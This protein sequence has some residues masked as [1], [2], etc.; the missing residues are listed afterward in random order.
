MEQ[1]S[2]MWIWWM[3]ASVIHIATWSPVD[4]MASKSNYY[5]VKTI[6]TVGSQLYAH[7]CTVE[8][9]LRAPPS[10]GHY[11]QPHN[12]VVGSKKT[13]IW[14]NFHKGWGMACKEWNTVGGCGVMLP[15]GKF[16]KFLKTA[17]G[18]FSDA[19]FIWWKCKLD[20]ETHIKNNSECSKQWFLNSGTDNFGL[21]KLASWKD[22]MLRL[23]GYFTNLGKTTTLAVLPF[24]QFDSEHVLRVWTLSIDGCSSSCARMRVRVWLHETSF[25]ERRRAR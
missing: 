15:P 3:G 17:S 25:R 1:E 18:G 20:T 21:A 5:L 19:N 22:M 12:R 11:L 7:V 6:L 14:P 8:R 13:P 2:G 4:S 9:P 16:F 10:T 24:A 23:V